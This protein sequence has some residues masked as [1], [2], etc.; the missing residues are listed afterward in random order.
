[1]SAEDKL[2]KKPYTT[3]SYTPEM[4]QELAA[5][6]DPETGPLFFIE[7]FVYIRHPTKGRLKFAPFDYQRELCAVY[8]DHKYSIAMVGRQMGKT[9]LAAAYLLWYAMFKSDSTILI[10]AHKYSGAQEIMQYIRYAYESLPDHIRAGVTSYNKGSIEFDNGSR[11]VA[12]TT[13]PTTGRG[14]A[15]SLVYLDE[16][17]FVQP[18]IA[19]EFWTSISPTLS[20]GG[21]CIITSTPNVDDDQFAEIWFGS[22]KTLDE[23]GNEKETGVNGFKGYVAT[24]ESHPDRDDEWAE[25]ERQKIGEDRFDREH[26]CMF[27][28]F[29][30]TL[31]T[32]AK[33]LQLEP[34]S[35]IRKTG[36]I[37]WY[38]KV[39]NGRYYC[40]SLDPSMG[41]GGDYSAI[42]VLEL[43]TMRQVAEWRHNKT[44]IEQQ[45]KILKQIL[46]EI[47]TEAP[48]SEIYWTVENNGMGEAALV[49]IREMGEEAFPGTFL[50]EPNR[51]V[52]AKNRRKG[53]T[54]TNKT[55][56]EACAKLKSLVENDRI[57]L[58]SKSL[59]HELKYF[60]AKGN[61]FEA[62]IGET[63][64]LVMAMLT[65]IRIAQMV[66]HWEDDL[67]HAMDT[68]TSE[69]FVDDE[70]EP[71]PLVIV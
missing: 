24:W 11:I 10:A 57:I 7:N 12:Q 13:T 54:T 52:S 56:L 55:K 61:S 21:K 50:H 71:M 37:R 68:A 20:T 39:A 53:F 64:D 49:V 5:C 51:A 18:R 43:P 9:T 27:V 59:I 41:T 17:A 65:N 69:S 23:F 46:D 47:K 15:I 1:M 70:D 33:L 28:S 22:Q 63:D 30:E 45:L 19:R 34:E 31:I 38:G 32:G 42:Q 4:V 14:M 58:K 66:S 26:C 25:E 6:A 48:K 62:N 3:V 40:V 60:I 35:P 2:V 36:E 16:F 44:R 29:S 67:K 8:H